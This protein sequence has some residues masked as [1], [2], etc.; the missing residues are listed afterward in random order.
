MKTSSVSVPVIV[1]RIPEEHEEFDLS[2]NVPSSLGLT[3]AVGGRD[4]AL[5]VITDSASKCKPNNYSY[6]Y[7]KGNM[8]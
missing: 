4:S 8:G 3:I 1:D 7:I 6:T 2:L 5:G